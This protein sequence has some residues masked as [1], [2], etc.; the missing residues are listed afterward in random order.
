MA[1]KAFLVGVNDDAPIGSGG[2][3]LNGIV[4]FIRKQA[5]PLFTSL[6]II[7]SF[8]HLGS[9]IL[10]LLC[11]AVLWYGIHFIKNFIKSLIK[12]QNQ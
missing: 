1:K 10:E 7:N 11:F 3:D 4:S 9:F 6:F 5:I 2:S 8:V 12:T